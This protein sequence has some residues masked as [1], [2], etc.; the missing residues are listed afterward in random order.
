M[1]LTQSL[2]ASSVAALMAAAVVAPASAEIDVGASVGISNMYLWRGYD[3]GAPSG[4]PAVFGDLNVSTAGFFA[5]IWGSSGDVLAG[6]EYDL[7]AGYGGELGDFVYGLSVFNYI[8]PTGDGYLDDPETD[9]LEETDFGKLTDL[10]LKLGYGPVTLNYYDNVAGANG[11][12]FVTL[13]V[14]VSDFNLQLGQ[15][16]EGQNDLLF[17]TVTYKYNDNLSFAISAGLD[18]DDGDLDEDGEVIVVEEDPKFVVT[19]TL[20]LGE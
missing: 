11:Y 8:Y 12:S 18:S 4:A 10:A 3:L 14:A 15:H 1:K 9:K 17:G 16:I 6:T 20:P 7:Y 5:G 13:D 2:L 19:Y